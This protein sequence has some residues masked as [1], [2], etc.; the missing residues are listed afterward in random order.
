MKEFEQE[1]KHYDEH[2][3]EKKYSQKKQYQ[4]IDMSI[5]FVE[6][7]DQE[8]ELYYKKTAV[9]SKEKYETFADFVEIEVSCITCKKIFSSRN[10]L[11]KHFKNCKFAK[12]VKIKK[13]VSSSSKNSEKS[14]IVKSTTS[15]SNKDYELTFRK[16]N[17]AEAMMKLRSNLNVERNY[18]FFDIEIEAFLTDKQFVLKKFFKIHVHLMIN[19][20]IVKNIKSNVHEIKKYVNFSIY[21][22]SRDD[23]IKLIEIHRELHLVKKLKVNM[24]IEN[25][26]LRSKE[27]IIDVQQKIAIIRNCENLIIEVKIHQR[28]SFVKRNVVNQFAILVSF[29]FYVKIF[30]KIKNLFT[31]RDFLFESSSEVSIFIYTH[32]IDAR[33][34][35]VIIRNEF[36]KLMKISRNFKLKMTQKIQYD[37]CF[38]VSQKHHLTL[39]TFKKN[40]IFEDL[41]VELTI[42]RNFNVDRSRSS[43]K[44]SKVRVSA[45]QID[46]KFEEKISFD[47]IVYENES[48]KQKFDKLI[49]EFSQIWKNEEFIDVLKKQWMRF[50]LKK[51]WQDKMIVKTK[52]YSLKTDDRKVINDIFNRLQ[53]QNRLKFTIETTSFNYSVFVMWIVKNDVRKDKIIVNI[54]DLNALLISNVYSVSSQSEIIDD[55]LECKYLSILNVNA[56]FYQWRVHSKDVYKQTIMIHREQ[57]IFLIFIM[58]NRNSIAYVQRQMNILLND[59]RKFVR[60]Y[61][62]NIICRSKTFQE[63]LNHLRILFRIFLK[64]EIIINSLKTFLEYQSVILLKQRVNAFELIT[65]EKKLKAIALLKFSKNLTALKKYLELTD[66]LRDKIYF[67]AKVIMSLQKLKTKLLKNS[68]AKARR[69]EFI[70]RTEI[71][72]VNKKMIS[73][74][75]LQENL[76]KT[77]FLIHFDK[78]KWLWINLDEFKKFDF[79][80][81]VFHVIKEFSKETWSIKNDIQL[82]MFL[83]R[84]LIFVEKNYWSTELKT[85]ELIWIIK[86]MK[87]LIQSFEKSVIIQIDHAAILNIC[88]QTFIISTNSTMRM[89]LRL[90]RAFQFLSQFSNLEIRHKSKKYHLISD[91]LFRLQSLNKKN[92]SDDHA[93]LD[94]LFVDHNVIYAYNTILMKLSSEFRKKIIESYFRNESWNKIIHIINQNEALNENVVELSFVQES[95]TVFRKSNFYMTSNI[96]SKSSKQIS[97]FNETQKNSRSSKS[98]LRSNENSKESISSEHDDKDL[99]YHVNKLIEKKRLCIS[100]NC[101]SNILIIAHERKQKHSNF[102]ITFE[103]IFRSWYIRDLIKT[104]RFY[105]RNCSQC[106]QIQIRR[107]KSWKSLQFIHSSSMF[108]HTIAMNFVLEL[109]KINDEL[110][111]VL[112]ITNK[113][114][115]RIMLISRKFTYTAED[116][117]IHLLK[118]TQRRDWDISKM[119]IFDRNRK[120][121]SDLWRTLFTKINVFMLYS[122]IYHSQTNEASERTNQTLKIALRYYIQKMLDSTLWISALWKF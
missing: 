8:N 119:I 117:A 99:I 14:I 114:I 65:T 23:S 51:S 40:S 87:H 116:W 20:L 33:T 71:I 82:I 24:L 16:W 17:Y 81:I 111:C 21:L 115:K 95:A 76:I 54:Q 11:H 70:N 26:I 29:D 2:E 112:S 50:S 15:V 28:E 101:V 61:I 106:L 32:V 5:N 77:T 62:D 100:F 9:N 74:L 107:Y 3:Y 84:L 6:Y 75:L 113:F 68:S 37:D 66:Y 63:H 93:K 35:D 36:A 58:N 91:A 43:S 12:I 47:V 19:S 102:E 13:T 80:V 34:T 109:L 96:D 25:D 18:V 46:E 122:T 4:K 88:K 86:T 92:L 44:N 7:D 39:Q 1:Q 60:A 121:L 67:F 120:F 30:Y 103:I 22:F 38:H 55:L 31:N 110:N 85:A 57:K 10:K 79:E 41:N 69:K 64:K 108:F 105:I 72:F 59:L 94:K 89:N 78:A 27:I 118:E 98:V 97:S 49:N 73:F 45:D 56:F 104:L 52:I 48:E 53:T 42:E 83:S 90:M